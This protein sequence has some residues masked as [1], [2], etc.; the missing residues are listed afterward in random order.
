[1]SEVT[2]PPT[3]NTPSSGNQNRKKKGKK[4]KDKVKTSKSK[5]KGATTDLGDD[6][7][8]AL[9]NELGA[10]RVISYKTTVEAAEVFAAVKFPKSAKAMSSL[11]KDP[12]RNPTIAVPA[13]PVG[14]DLQDTLVVTLYIEEAKRAN[15]EQT[16]LDNALHGMFTILW[17]QCSP[18]V[19]AKVR[20]N[21][22]FN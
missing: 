1:M 4:G 6:K 16:L 10:D 18:G 19:Q 3:T 11:F 9:K 5:L 14:D 7:V 13:R 22:F 2:S 12:P 8:F 21:Q 17:G 20:G 15:A